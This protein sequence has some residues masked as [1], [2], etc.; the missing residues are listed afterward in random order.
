MTTPHKYAEVIKA[1]ADGKEIQYRVN[2]SLN[3]TWNDYTNKLSTPDFGG[4]STEWRI[5]P[6][7]QTGW[8]NIY[9]DGCSHL[10]QDRQSADA[11]ASVLVKRIASIQI[12]YEEGQGLT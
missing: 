12:E 11:G 7:K 10:Y 1:W 3:S 8:V 4:L 6:K 9:P 2:S 5:K